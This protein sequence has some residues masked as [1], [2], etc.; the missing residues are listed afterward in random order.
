MPAMPKDL[1]RGHLLSSSSQRWWARYLQ[2]F[3]PSRKW[4][5]A[6]EDPSTRNVIKKLKILKIVTFEFSCQMFWKLKNGRKFELLCQ[7]AHLKQSRF[8]IWFLPKLW[9]FTPKNCAN[10]LFFIIKLYSRDSR[11]WALFLDR[12]KSARDPGNSRSRDSREEALS[13]CKQIKVM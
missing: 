3:S 13:W 8:E 2:I 12:E 10:F 7:K 9:I 5:V 1:V 6:K 11:D 4:N